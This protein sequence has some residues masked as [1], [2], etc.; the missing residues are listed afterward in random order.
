M[1]DAK[2]QYPEHEKL[3]AVSDKSQEIGQFLDWMRDEK[4]YQFGFLGDADSGEDPGRIYPT[5][6]DVTRVLADYFDI[7]L[8]KIEQEKREMLK[9]IRSADGG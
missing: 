6:L 4:G 7:D 3:K 2:E 8:K 5:Y 1:T 9:S